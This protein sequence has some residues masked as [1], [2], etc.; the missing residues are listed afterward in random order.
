MI[1]DVK[2]WIGMEETK[3]KKEE[4]NQLSWWTISAYSNEVNR[5]YFVE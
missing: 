4:T 1:I 5:F 3:K 2:I